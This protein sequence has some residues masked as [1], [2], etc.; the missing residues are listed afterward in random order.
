[1][2]MPRDIVVL[3]W[4]ARQSDVWTVRSLGVPI[5]VGTGPMHRSLGHLSDAG[6]LDGERRS[7][8]FAV[9][10]EFVQHAVRF[11]AADVPG[12]EVRGIPTAWGDPV[13]DGLIAAG[14]AAPVWPF[15]EGKVRGPALTPLAGNA[16]Q[17]RQTQPE[18]ATDLAI[19]DAI[20]IGD[21][22]LR[23]VATELLLDRMFGP[24]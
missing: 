16:P 3:L 18:L 22:R 13:F 19:V 20:R 14:G 12:A 11:I 17:L 4:L 24:A 7:V 10:R 15:P 5:G 23:R 21:T 1:M 9:T 6:L 2:I 8:N